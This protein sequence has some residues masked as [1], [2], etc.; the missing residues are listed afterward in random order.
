MTEHE[1]AEARRLLE[2]AQDDEMPQEQVDLLLAVWAQGFYTGT[3]ACLTNAGGYP[4]EQADEFALHLTNS[5]MADDTQ[6]ARIADHIRAGAK[7]NPL[8]SEQI[9][10]RPRPM[11]PPS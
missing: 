2:E 7:G 3:S 8:P 6:R 11:E 10:I 1:E 5:L 9:V 4:H